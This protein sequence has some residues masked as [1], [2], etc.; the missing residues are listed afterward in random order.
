MRIRL[1]RTL[2]ALLL[3]LAVACDRTSPVAMDAESKPGPA[4]RSEAALFSGS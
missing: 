4:R 3:L 1:L 2:P